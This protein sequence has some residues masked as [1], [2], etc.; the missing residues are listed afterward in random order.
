MNSNTPSS[1]FLSSVKALAFNVPQA[2]IAV[3][4]AALTAD[5]HA[6]EIERDE[7]VF[8][9][10]RLRL[11]RGYETPYLQEQLRLIS[12]KIKGQEF[13]VV[14]G[15]VRSALTPQLHE[16]AFLVATELALVDDALETKEQVVLEKLQVGL[17]IDVLVANRIIEVIRIRYRE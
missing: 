10:R 12:Q 13:G 11:L 17:K 1:F 15:A 8:V 5:G 16:T 2:I 4:I 7:L 14:I 9:L 3:A 6:S